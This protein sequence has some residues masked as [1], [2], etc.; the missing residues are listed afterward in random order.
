MENPPIGIVDLRI[1]FNKVKRI[2]D[3]ELTLQTYRAL[4][5]ALA[6]HHWRVMKRAGQ[7]L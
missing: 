3:R 2:D 7:R 4:S 1:L 5:K 6:D